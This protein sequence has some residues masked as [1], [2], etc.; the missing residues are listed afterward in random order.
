MA[1]NIAI[2]TTNSHDQRGRAATKMVNMVFPQARCTTVP[3]RTL[4][5]DFWVLKKGTKETYVKGANGPANFAAQWERL[6]GKYDAIVCFDHALA[7]Y[8]LPERD[9][10]GITGPDPL[11][12]MI[13][14]HGGQTVLFII[15]PLWTY[16]R[17]YSEEQRAASQ[18]MTVFHL[19]KLWS[20]LQDMPPLEKPIQIIVPTSVSELR[21]AAAMAAG[22]VAIAADIETSGGFISCIG[23]ACECPDRA[24]NPVFVIPLFTN[25]DDG[26]FWKDDTTTGFALSTIGRI[27]GNDVPKIF[28]NGGTFDVAWLFRYGWCPQNYV[29]DTMIMM[30]ATWQSMPKALY[31]AASMLLGSYRYW[32][33]DGKD[34]DDSGK[35]KWQVPKTPDAILRYWRYNGMDCANTLEVFVAL[36]RMWDNAPEMAGRVPQSPVPYDYAWRNYVRSF[37]LQAGPALYMSMHGM[38]VDEKRKAALANKMRA[39]GEKGLAELRVLLDDPEFNP[40]SSQQVGHV[41]YDVLDLKPLAR[42]G[43][44]TDKKVIQTFADMHPIY[45]RVIQ[46]IA[47][48][49]EPANNASKY[50]DKFETWNGRALYSLKAAN[51]VTFRF[52]SSQHAFR[53]G[54]NYQNYP[55]EMREFHV[56]DPG[57]VLCSIDYSQSDSYFVAFESGDQTMIETVTDDRDTHSVHVEFFFGYSYESVMS[58]AKAKEPWVVHP[59][60]GVRQII[61]KVTHGTNYDMQGGTML[62]N[63]RRDA[64]VAMCNAL[65]QSRNGVL[66]AKYM[67]LPATNRPEDF[68]GAAATWPTAQLEKACDFAQ[69]LYYIRYKTLA[70]WKKSAVSDAARRWGLIPVFGGSTAVMICEPHKNQRF[71]PAAYGQG[72]T[73]GNINNAML[74]LYL[75][76]Q[77]MWD[78]GFRMVLQVHDELVSSIP[79]DDL[80]LV[81][82]QSAIMEAPCVIRGRKFV[83]P[84]EAELS[85]SWS[86]K[87]TVVF[88]GLDKMTAAEYYSAISAKEQELETALAPYAPKGIEALIAESLD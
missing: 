44:T 27:L 77:Y 87:K 42:K 81:Q 2:I 49:K 69:K 63:I 84:V 51:T 43:R 5:K 55:A 22:S 38:L 68:I 82:L 54:T 33:D 48:A 46:A 45:E 6:R 76:N 85:L 36:L 61:K 52:A 53:T 50:G 34:V 25:Y 30:Y 86:K 14:P 32:K 21:E 75:L 83:V 8:I 60:T 39:D 70:S 29:W 65:L 88:K 9:S 31:N 16:G 62:V 80:E 23:F 1:K 4:V 40:N 17:Q 26:S 24:V 67:G 78:R 74:R 3:L 19:R 35:T 20:L 12:G 47:A 7:H 64:A 72:G 28:H 66:F 73:A 59:I 71:V 79:K 11:G 18:L 58:G 41:L 56:A 57:T 15:D 10:A 37:T 13:V